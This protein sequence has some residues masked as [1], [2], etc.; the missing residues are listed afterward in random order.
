MSISI[1][2]T[3]QTG[4]DI[5]AT[6]G[7]TVAVTVSPSAAPGPTGPQ[8]PAGPSNSLSIGTVSG[9]GTASATISGTAP[10]Q[11]LSLVLPK[12]DAGA[13][14]ELQAT[15]THIQ[16]RYAG[17]S[18]WTNLVAL[19]AITG[20]T[21]STG[22]AG[23]AVELQATSTHLQWRYVGA[24]TWTNVFA[25]SSLVGAT[26]PAGPAGPAGPPV[27][28]A[29]ETPQPLGLASAGTALTAS[30][31]DHRHAVPV[32]AYGSLTGTP[33]TFAPSA[34]SHAVSD[35]TGLQA[36]LDDKQ[37]SGT[38]ATLV[39]GT[40]PSSQLPSYVDDVREA[41]SFSAFPTTGDAGVIYVAVDTKK[42]FRWGGSAYVEISPSPGT[43]TDVPEGTNLYFTNARAVAAIP[44]ASDTVAGI[45]KVGSGLSITGGVLAATGSGFTLPTAS[46]TVLGGIKVGANLTITDGVLAATATGGDDARWNYFKPPAPPSI[47]AVAGDTQVAVSWGLPTVLAQTPIT[48]HALQYSID[49]ST[50]TTWS[51]SPSYT[52]TVV[53]S[54]QNGTAH[55]FRVASINGIG[56]GAWK[57]TTNAVIPLAPDNPIL[58]APGLYAWYDTSV[59]ASLFSTQAGDS[60]VTADGAAVNRIR[61]QTGNGRDLWKYMTGSS[62]TLV[63][64]GK[65]GKNIVLFNNL[66]N[67]RPLQTAANRESGAFNTGTPLTIFAVWRPMTAWST[68]V[69]DL[70]YSWGDRQAGSAV[71][72][73]LEDTRA[74]MAAF[75]TVWVGDGSNRV[76]SWMC[77]RASMNG[78]N[79][80]MTVNG[81]YD[82]P[83]TYWNGSSST[84][85][86]MNFN[87]PCADFQVSGYFE[88]AELLFYSGALD[89]TT[90]SAIETF[91]MNKWGIT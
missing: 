83:T 16:W 23:T 46:S 77:Q 13:A 65:N 8:G 61:D 78:T 27:S 62:P 44:T 32:I 33:T 10:S 24:T 73:G 64:A 53:G 74:R 41:A 60:L 12:G 17:A 3:G 82:A 58:A 59:G 35:V 14:V 29:D 88:F 54:L 7:D 84:P 19:S 40:V 9:G 20:P 70:Y 81:S 45:V 34:H 11:T 89:G 91:L 90:C 49:Q 71:Q 85:S 21:G 18:S 75:S 28:L 72:I 22:A 4:P 36:L 31:A 50:W 66:N 47:T 6:T 30:R 38:Y 79:S 87:L 5:V 86:A 67:T 76:G 52:G 42:I 51:G 15:S 1:T 69:S 48:G 37:A 25:L 39:N 63:A 56:Q 57:T 55:W 68:L 2:V 26:G 43:T 80:T